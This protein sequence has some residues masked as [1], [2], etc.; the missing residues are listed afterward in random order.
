M[1][2]QFSSSRNVSIGVN[3][4]KLLVMRAKFV[5]LG[6]CW[7]EPVQCYV[8]WHQTTTS[9]IPRPPQTSFHFYWI[10]LS[11]PSLASFPPAE[12]YQSII[13][14]CYIAI[15]LPWFSRFMI[16]YA[17]YFLLKET[18][19][20]F[21][22]MR[23]GS[24]SSHIPPTSHIPPPTLCWEASLLPQTTSGAND[25]KCWLTESLCRHLV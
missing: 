1:A 3:W 8:A 11:R 10:F 21:C 9:H 19:L 18:S 5:S 20:V 14:L 25:G 13:D 22:C 2:D 15:S 24:T 16:C 12:G 17:T 4:P 7:G 23:E 6:F